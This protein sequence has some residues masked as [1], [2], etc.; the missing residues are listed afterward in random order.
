MK[1]VLWLAFAIIFASSILLAGCSGAGSG[2]GGGSAG[3]NSTVQE[4][5]DAPQEKSIW[6][7]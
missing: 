7:D 5:T 3:P 1:R 4:T 2:T 6:D